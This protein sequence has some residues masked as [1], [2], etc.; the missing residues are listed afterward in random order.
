MDPRISPIAR[1]ISVAVIATTVAGLAAG[2]SQGR[3][4][5]PAP[6]PAATSAEAATGAAAQAATD[7]ADPATWRLPMEAYLPTDEEYRRYGK[8]MHARVSE[9][10]RKAGYTPQPLVDVPP[11][12]G[13]TLTDRRY[14]IHDETLSA[15]RGYH[16]DAQQQAA[17]DAAMQES[18]VSKLGPEGNR[19]EF[20]CGT[21]S[22]HWFGGGDKTLG[23]LA[24]E[25]G[26]D[27]FLRAKR[28]PE[29]VAAFKAWS[30]CMKERGYSYKEPFDAN[31]DPRMTGREV[32]KPEI[33]TALADIA[34]R[35]RSNVAKIWYDA[36]VRLQKDAFDKQAPALQAERKELD[37]ILKKTADVLG[38]TR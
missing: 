35:T 16:V 18:A 22:K 32:S 28:E 19:A 21:Q 17:Y 25:L 29:V 27:A 8:A 2:C 7:P 37:A 24:Q 34:C 10:M 4:S 13:R 20:E 5:S 26:N 12:G 31:D 36:E 38:G 30:S 1:R 11:I 3:A 33:D 6:A 9:C 23:A 14:G 15:K